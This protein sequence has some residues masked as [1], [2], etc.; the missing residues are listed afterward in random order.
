MLIPIL[1][2]FLICVESVKIPQRLKVGDTVGFISPAGIVANHYPDGIAKYKQH[3]L[4]FMSKLGLKVEFAAHAFGPDYGYLAANDE[5]RAA[6]VMAMFKNQ[7]IAAIVANRGG[8]GCDRILELLDFNVIKENPKPI[9]GYSD[10]TTLINSIAHLGDMVTF[11]GPMGIDEWNQTWNSQY[12]KNVLI[13]GQAVEFTNQDG[14][15]T[16]TIVGGKA[17]GTLVGGNLAVFTSMIGSKFIPQPH[18]KFILFLE[19]V[20]E[21]PYRVD[22]MLTQ[23]QLT[24]WFSNVSGIVW[25]RCTTCTGNNFSVSQLLKQK[26]G[27]LNIPVFSGAMIGHIHE[28]YTLPLGTMVEID[29]DKGSIR[30]LEPAVQ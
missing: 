23:L 4:S 20:G 5:E 29:A 28:Q 8:W 30:M 6:D 13:E 3:V 16:T 1:I 19:E 9:V 18:Q 21:S 26:F 14:V 24:D 27:H 15:S 11:H 25:G 2:S 7:N 12:F 17:R 22:R 10:L